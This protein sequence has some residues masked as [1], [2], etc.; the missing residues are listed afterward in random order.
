MRAG[1]IVS[2]AAYKDVVVKHSRLFVNT[3]HTVVIMFHIAR[4]S[5]RPSLTTPALERAGLGHRNQHAEL[6]QADGLQH[7]PSMD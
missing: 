1:F 7:D 6:I 3:R 4:T 5:R 2:T